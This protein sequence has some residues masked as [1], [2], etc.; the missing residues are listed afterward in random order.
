ANGYAAVVQYNIT[1]SVQTVI[2]RDEQKSNID[3]L[4]HWIADAGK[5]RFIGEIAPAQVCGHEVLHPEMRDQKDQQQSA[6][7]A[8]QVPTED[9]STHWRI[10]IPTPNLRRVEWRPPGKP[11]RQVQSTRPR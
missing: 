11:A 4:P 3:R 5:N 1:K 7:N 8:L 10:S 6:G 2:Q 9:G